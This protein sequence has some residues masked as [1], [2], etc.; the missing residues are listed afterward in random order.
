MG[1]TQNWDGPDIIDFILGTDAT[2]KQIA[3]RFIATK[4]WTFFAYPDPDDT[5]VDDRSRATFLANDLSIDDARARD[6][7]AP[8]LPVDRRRSKGSCA[9]PVE[10]VVACMRAVGI[11]ADAG[12]P[13]VVDGRHGPAA[14]RAA[15]R[16]GLATERVLAHD[17]AAVGTR[18]LVAATS[19]GA[20]TSAEH[21][22]RHHG[23]ERPRRGPARRSTSS[24]STARR[25]T[26]A[27]K[28]EAWLTAQ[29]ADNARVDELDVHQPADPGDAQP[30]IQPRLGV[31]P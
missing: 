18:E 11:T 26:P 13:A 24:A 21:A 7:H 1:V 22:E 12:E 16:V 2:H 23:H 29:R 3:A 17:V 19:S 10:W 6:L 15:E 25:R 8:E 14:L 31:R 4:M 30:G 28:L 9:R 5:I 20:T 27:A